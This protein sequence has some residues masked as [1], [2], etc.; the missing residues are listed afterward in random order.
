MIA[1]RRAG[2]DRSQTQRSVLR[3]LL[4][5]VALASGGQSALGAEAKE[6]AWRVKIPAP[7]I[8]P[9]ITHSA[10]LQSFDKSGATCAEAGRL[11]FQCLVFQDDR[12]KIAAA[13][14]ASNPFD[15]PVFELVREK[16]RS[17]L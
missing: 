15:L 13:D 4:T 9:Y 5:V 16:V 1:A 6:A 11:N 14:T 17:D 3:T 10:T 8:G 12:T 7:L 2:S